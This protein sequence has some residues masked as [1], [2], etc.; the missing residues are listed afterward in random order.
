MKLKIIRHEKIMSKTM[1]VFELSPSKSVLTLDFHIFF[2][3]K[4][5]NRLF[6]FKIFFVLLPQRILKKSGK[7]CVKLRKTKF[8][9]G[10]LKFWH[11]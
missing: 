2:Y 6:S 5:S 9:I 4:K 7:R 10:T 3:G 8:Q 1:S 11:C